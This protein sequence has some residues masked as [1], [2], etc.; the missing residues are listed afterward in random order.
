MPI[1]TYEYN[2]YIILHTY[3]NT[4]CLCLTAFLITFDNNLTQRKQLLRDRNIVADGN[5][6]Y[7]TTHYIDTS[8]LHNILVIISCVLFN[9][10]YNIFVGDIYRGIIL[11][12][13]VFGF[14]RGNRTRVS[15]SEVIIKLLLLRYS[16]SVDIAE[17]C[18]IV[19]LF[20]FVLQ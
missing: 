18:G 13:R 9:I 12:K 15:E 17:Y 3:F 8:C 5:V 14:H 11:C 19:F 1:V 2:E 10:V 6:K 16:T 20:I 7:A 4:R